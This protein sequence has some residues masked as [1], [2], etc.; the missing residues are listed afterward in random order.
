MSSVASLFSV[1]SSKDFS[2]NIIFNYKD[3][4]TFILGMAAVSLNREIYDFLRT[5]INF[6][7][8]LYSNESKYRK[9]ELT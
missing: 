2:R 4:L 8:T 3:T 6:I 5:I 1:S 7:L 9:T